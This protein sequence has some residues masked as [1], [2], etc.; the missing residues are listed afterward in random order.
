M[1]SVKTRL[2]LLILIIGLSL[3][4]CQSQAE[5][6]VA[7]PSGNPT[8]I[9]TVEVEQRG[10]DYYAVVTGWYPDA[11]SSTGDIVQEVDGDTIYL[12]IYSTRPE[13]MVC[14]QMLTDFSDDIL[15][16]TDGL[17]SG[18]YSIIVNEDNAR[19]TFTL[20]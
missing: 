2:M 3:A 5:P 18:V 9:Q 13:D 8:F 20:L 12:T 1:N 14:A 19:T 7:E 11:C 16:D 17:E 10:D 6:E 4:A 15:L